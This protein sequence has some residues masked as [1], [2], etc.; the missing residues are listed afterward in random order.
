MKVKVLDFAGKWCSTCIVLDKMLESE[1]IPKYKN[2]VKFVKIDIEENEDLTKQ[3]DILSVPTLILLK[4]D[5]EIWRKSGS[6]IKEEIIE[7][8]NKVAK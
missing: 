1:I 8:L 6:I 4:D 3:Y 5:K 7:Q 2:K